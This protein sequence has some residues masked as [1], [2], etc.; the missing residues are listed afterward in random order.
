MVSLDGAVKSGFYNLAEEKKTIP[1]ATGYS[2]ARQSVYTG[3]INEQ[4]QCEPL[5]SECLPF[6]RGGRLLIN[7]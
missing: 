7:P 2:G 6:H 1:Y 3:Y 5:L 4:M